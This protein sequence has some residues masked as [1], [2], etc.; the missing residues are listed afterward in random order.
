MGLRVEVCVEGVRGAVAAAEGGADRVELCEALDVDGLTPHPAEVAEACRRLTIPVHV[1]IR[2]RAGGFIHDS[3]EFETMSQS[4]IVAKRS[5]ALGI[6]IGANRPDGSVDR[7]LVAALVERARPLSVTFHKAF[8]TTA[9]PMAALE[10]LIA[11]GIDRVL[12]SGQ[13]ATAREGLGLLEALVRRAAGRIVV[14]AGGRVREG[15]LPALGAAGIVEVHG[16]SAVMTEGQTD[17]AKVR[18]FVMAA[19]RVVV[20]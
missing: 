17:P 18:S 20:S 2:P 10:D 6:V 12:T 9:D 15:D 7:A 13:A 11:L 4:L 16:A 3:S 8:D 1:L 5:G 14:M 19:R